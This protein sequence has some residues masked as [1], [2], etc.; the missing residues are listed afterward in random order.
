MKAII[1][2]L[3]RLTDPPDAHALTLKWCKRRRLAASTVIREHSE[4]ARK[5]QRLLSSIKPGTTVVAYSI[6]NF[7]TVNTLIQALPRLRRART[8]LVFVREKLV[9][10]AGGTHLRSMAMFCELLQTLGRA[11]RHESKKRSVLIAQWLGK[12]VGREGLSPELREEALALLRD[13]KSSR[14]V[15]RAMGGR[16]GKTTVCKLARELRFKTLPR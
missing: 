15:V 4:R 10:R 3:V 8:T 12:Q 6:F 7:G 5:L 2:H 1:Y 9:F 16:V 14:Q 11:Q 13:G